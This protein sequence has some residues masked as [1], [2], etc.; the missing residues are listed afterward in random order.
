MMPDIPM[1]ELERRFLVLFFFNCVYARGIFLFLFLSKF[2]EVTI[3]KRAIYKH[4]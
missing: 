3:T 1:S 4:I 2:L